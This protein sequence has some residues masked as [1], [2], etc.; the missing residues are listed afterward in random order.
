MCASLLMLQGEGVG[1]TRADTTEDAATAKASSLS[2][3]CLHSSL[4]TAAAIASF[5]SS[6]VC[7]SGMSGSVCGTCVSSRDHTT[8]SSSSLSFCTASCPANEGVTAL[9]SCT[10]SGSCTPSISSPVEHTS[11]SYHAHSSLSPCISTPAS[12]VGHSSSLLTTPKIT[13]EGLD[14][15]DGEG[16]VRTDSSKRRRNHSGSRSPTSR[17]AG[18][19]KMSGLLEGIS[20]GLSSSFSG[21]IKPSSLS[22]RGKFSP[23]LRRRFTSH[24]DLNKS[25]NKGGESGR[26][27]TYR[28]L[29]LKS[30]R[31]LEKFSMRRSRG[32]SA[33]LTNSPAIDEESDLSSSACLSEG[34]AGTTNESTEMDSVDDL[35]QSEAS[36]DHCNESIAVSPSNPSLSE[37]LPN[38]EASYFTDSGF[39]TVSDQLTSLQSMSVDESPLALSTINDEIY[40]NKNVK[41][42]LDDP[43]IHRNVS[44]IDNISPLLP[45]NVP[46]TQTPSLISLPSHIYTCQTSPVCVSSSHAHSSDSCEVVAAPPRPSFATSSTTVNVAPKLSVAP[47]PPADAVGTL[48]RSASDHA[49][50]RLSLGKISSSSL[51]FFY[52]ST[53]LFQFRVFSKNTFVHMNLSN[54]C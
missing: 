31:N 24:S 16:P 13:C 33:A 22:M 40:S 48:T 15:S 8:S 47:P 28:D 6:S 41:P 26:H 38:L 50:A 21:V 17:S 18:G 3:L 25:Q 36:I 10:L 27:T 51:I 9:S 30:L 2:S 14:I 11:S 5:A 1:M 46:F 39:E 49:A 35:L 4:T 23:T 44:N 32:E 20:G 19:S 54:I 29:R 12:N 52:L 42:S 37:S 7:A 43:I 53:L 34:Y 45:E